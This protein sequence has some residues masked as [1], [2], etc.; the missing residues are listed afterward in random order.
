MGFA[1]EALAASQAEARTQASDG[2]REGSRFSTSSQ[3]GMVAISPWVGHKGLQIGKETHWLITRP[4]TREMIQE[5]LRNLLLS[6]AVDDLNCQCFHQHNLS[7]NVC[8]K[9][10]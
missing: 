9:S 1:A 5:E 2:L 7:G 4:T 10:D 6:I 3:S 8:G